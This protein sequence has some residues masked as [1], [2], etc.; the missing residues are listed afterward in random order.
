MKKSEL[1][2]TAIQVPLDFVMILLAAAFT[3]FLR[4]TEFTKE[5]R[6]VMFDLSFSK[7]I[8]LILIVA[9]GILIIFAILGFIIL[10][11]KRKFFEIFILFLLVFHVQWRLFRFI[12]FCG[13]NFFL[14]GF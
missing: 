13:Q 8:T 6:P 1:F 5:I 10:K 14:P 9:S 11:E 12:F 4:F 2:F 3:Y 7:F